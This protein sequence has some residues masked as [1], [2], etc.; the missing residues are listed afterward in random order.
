MKITT[1]LIYLFMFN[2]FCVKSQQID[3]DKIKHHEIGIDLYPVAIS[4]FKPDAQ[5]WWG[6]VPSI[7]P[8][9][10]F[11]YRYYYKN[12]AVKSRFS[13]NQ[14]RNGETIINN[15]SGNIT[16]ISIIDP[17]YDKRFSGTLGFQFNIIQKKKSHAFVGIDLLNNMNTVSIGN[18]N[19]SYDSNSNYIMINKTHYTSKNSL[20]S[21]G[22]A[23]VF[24]MSFNLNHNLYFTLESS[25]R[26][27]SSTVKNENTNYTYQYYEYNSQQQTETVR[28]IN[29]SNKIPSSATEFIP[30]SNFTLSYR[31]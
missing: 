26:Y 21:H 12:F 7:K 22:V 9:Y 3:T 17:G 2:C 31:F 23:L 27:V 11:T 1:T 25:L 10:N 14:N 29:S 24:G 13:I 28:N 8:D 20:R 16:Y 6:G 4:I 30:S 15:S 19:Q 5:S 18:W